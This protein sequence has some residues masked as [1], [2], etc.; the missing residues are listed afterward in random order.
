MLA[1]IRDALMRVPQN[2]QV[3]DQVGDQVKSLIRGF[4]NDREMAAADLMERLKL[5]HRPT[6]RKNYLNPALALGLIEMTDPESPK[7]PVQRYRLT[8][9]GRSL[10]R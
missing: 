5:R 2:D 4:K 8:D 9:L 10:K 7:S 3:S 1:A 6:F